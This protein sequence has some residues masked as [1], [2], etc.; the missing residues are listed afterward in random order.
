MHLLCDIGDIADIT[1]LSRSFHL[2]SVRS[3]APKEG[4]F[5]RKRWNTKALSN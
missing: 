1:A 5:L 2:T 3:H 4:P